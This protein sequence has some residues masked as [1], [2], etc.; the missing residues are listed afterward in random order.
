MLQYNWEVIL[1]AMLIHLPIRI[2]K[3]QKVYEVR[4]K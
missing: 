4:N 3:E 1:P 2:L